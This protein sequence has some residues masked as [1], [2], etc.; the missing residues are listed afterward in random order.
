MLEIKAAKLN[1]SWNST[2][3]VQYR[4]NSGVDTLVNKPV[5]VSQMGL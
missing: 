3:A 1:P 5:F 4:Q 2:A